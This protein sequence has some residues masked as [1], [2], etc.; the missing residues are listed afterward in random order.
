MGKNGECAKG[1]QTN[2]DMRCHCSCCQQ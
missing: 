1:Q 2:K